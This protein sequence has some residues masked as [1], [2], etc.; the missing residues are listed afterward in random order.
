M[1]R[2]L[3]AVV[4]AVLAV[5]IAGCGSSGSSTSAA[6]QA[7]AGAQT[8]CGAIAEGS[9]SSIAACAQGYDAAKA[10]KSEEKTCDSVGSGAIV[11][12]ENVQDCNDG[13]S[14]AD[15]AGKAAAAPPSAAAQTACGAVA[16]GSSSSIAACAQ[17]YDA[18]K[19][20]KSEEKTCDSVGSGAIVTP[21]NVQDCNDGWS[22]ADVAGKAAAAP[23]S[24]AAQTACGAVAEGSSSSIA[25]CAQG[26]DA[27][28]AGKSEE[29]TCDSVGSGAIVTPEN[30]QDCRAGWSAG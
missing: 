10:G 2:S 12:P 13:W 24:A 16:E 20:G 11:T 27:A 25:A 3:L 29:K 28:K 26:Y 6:A 22:A 15:V 30:V 4:I 21:E 17:G 14:A 5:P 1:P 9:S 8:A 23:P 19:A 18:A 7:S